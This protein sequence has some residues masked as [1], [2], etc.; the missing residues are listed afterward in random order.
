MK[1][2]R[3]NHTHL[4]IK[5]L[6]NAGAAEQ[7]DPHGDY[8][9]AKNYFEAAVSLSNPHDIMT[10]RVLIRLERAYLSTN[11]LQDSVA[12]LE[13]LSKEQLSP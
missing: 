4:T 6:F 8:E 12:I 9:Q 5:A 7:D 2:K 11:C 3:L 1:A 10:H 13:K